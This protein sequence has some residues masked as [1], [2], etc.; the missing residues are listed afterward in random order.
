MELGVWWA[1]LWHASKKKK[2]TRVCRNHFVT[3]PLCHYKWSSGRFMSK[4]ALCFG[5][6]RVYESSALSKKPSASNLQRS[7]AANTCTFGKTLWTL[8][9]FFD[10]YHTIVMHDTFVDRDLH[11]YLLQPRPSTNALS[12]RFYSMHMCQSNELRSTHEDIVREVRAT[13]EWSRAT[14]TQTSW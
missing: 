13:W 6:L 10:V 2:K 1:G 9:S 5:S 14:L 4:A 7:C 8:A 12:Q 11:T 3:V